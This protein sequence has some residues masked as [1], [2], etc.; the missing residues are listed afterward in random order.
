LQN[1]VSEREKLK[2]QLHK[3]FEESLDAKSIGNKKFF[4]Q[5][6]ND[7]HLNPA[8]SAAECFPALLCLH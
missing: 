3:V 7:I 5:K 2:G 4:L 6:L 1:A 8:C